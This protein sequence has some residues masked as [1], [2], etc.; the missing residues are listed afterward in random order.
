MDNLKQYYKIKKEIDEL[1]YIANVLYYDAT[2]DSPTKA[3]E[4]S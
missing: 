2:T 1:S 3:R 4:Y